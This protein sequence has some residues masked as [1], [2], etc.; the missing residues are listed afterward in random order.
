MILKN[1]RVFAMKKAWS[2][3]FVLCL[4]GAVSAQNNGISYQAVVRDSVNRLVENTDM[5]VVVRI[6]N[7]GQVIPP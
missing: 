4:Y 6:T 3:L 2:I 1:N 7:T 5:T